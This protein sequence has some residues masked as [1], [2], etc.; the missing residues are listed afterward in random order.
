MTSTFIADLAAAQSEMGNAALNKV[1]PHFKSKYADLAAVRAAILPA[2]NKH[3]FAVIQTTLVNGEGIIL[4]TELAHKS[5]ESR[6]SEYPISG[7]TPQQQGSAL[8]Y[9]RRYGLA[10][11]AGI[12]SE[13]DDDGNAASRGN[14]SWA[15]LIEE[16]RANKTAQE[17]SKWGLENADRIQATRG[18]KAYFR[19]EYASYLAELRSLENGGVKEQLRASVE[20]EREQDPVEKLRKRGAAPHKKSDRVNVMDAF[21]PDQWLNGLDAAMSACTDQDSLDEVW[22]GDAQDKIEA[23][24]VFPPDRQKADAIYEKHLA[25]LEETA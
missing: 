12:A 3:G 6:V 24:L 15:V 8:T 9:A 21:D 7:G 2:L 13:E 4:R 11:I 16:M 10:T 17:L 25:R 23:G 19:K 14:D 18:V 22:N 5:G 1:N 20:A